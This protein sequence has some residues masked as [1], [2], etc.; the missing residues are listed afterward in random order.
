MPYLGILS[1]RKNNRAHYSTPLLRSQVL[2]FSGKLWQISANV[3]S[4]QKLGKL[5]NKIAEND[6]SPHSNVKHNIDMNQAFELM[7]LL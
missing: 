3:P 1:Q 5:L 7:L 4:F 2:N 6:C